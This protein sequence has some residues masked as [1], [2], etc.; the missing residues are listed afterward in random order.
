MMEKLGMGFV[1]IGMEEFL[2]EIARNEYPENEYTRAFKA[3]GYKAEEG[4]EG[5]VC[6]RG[7]EAPVR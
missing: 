6:L 5:P 3:K 4:G 7:G 2:S 1:K